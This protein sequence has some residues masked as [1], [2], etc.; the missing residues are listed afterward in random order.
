MKQMFKGTILGVAITIIFS[1]IVNNK[2]HADWFNSSAPY[3]DSGNLK[4]MRQSMNEINNKLERLISVQK[5]LVAATRE[6]NE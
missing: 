6:K 3:S 5:D 1:L 2:S 4:A